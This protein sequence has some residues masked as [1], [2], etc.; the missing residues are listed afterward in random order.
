VNEPLPDPELAQ[1]FRNNAASSLPRAPL[2]AALCRTIAEDPRLYGLLRHAPPS[3]QL[4]VLLLAA[5]HSMLLDSVD[6]GD[7]ADA[8][9]TGAPSR[10]RPELASWYPNLS[11]DALPADD[12]RLP[13]VFTGFVDDHRE[14]IIGIV[15]TRHTQ[16]NEVGRS[17]L[18]LVAFGLLAEEMGALAHLDVGASAGLNLLVDRLAYHY[19]PDDVLD[20]DRDRDPGRGVGRRVGGP[21]TVELRVDTR[22]DVPVPVAPPSIVARCGIDRRPIDVTDEGEAHWLEACVWPDQIDRFERLRAVIDI[23]RADPPELLAGDAA[24]SLAPTAARLDRAGH[25]VV[26]NSWVLNYLSADERTEYVAAL[27]R[28]G[29]AIDLSWV[30]VESPGLTPELPW[31]TAPIESAVTA[32][33][34]ARWR[35]GRRSVEHLAVCHPH[36]YWMHWAA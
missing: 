36:G 31:A 6:A 9:G 24:T 1:R 2:Y 17:G 34:L 32:L 30:Y 26:T 13:G 8:D 25:V 7:T 23:A 18:L 28:V 12:R 10:A 16:T 19:V 35:D 29:S 22:G 4:P 15:A 5:V 33:N 14:E 11:A 20:D 21:S 3:Q 27:D